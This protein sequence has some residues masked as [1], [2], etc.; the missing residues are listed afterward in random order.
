[1]EIGA[2]LYEAEGCPMSEK[3]DLYFD[4]ATKCNVYGFYQKEAMIYCRMASL[5]LL[6]NTDPTVSLKNA[7]SAIRASPE[8]GE[9]SLLF[10]Q[11]H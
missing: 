10:Q 2:L 8:Y 7:D 1:M 5:N 3:L 6:Y 11:W 9:V 4:A